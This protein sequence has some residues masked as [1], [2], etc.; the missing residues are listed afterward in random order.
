MNTCCTSDRVASKIKVSIKE[1]FMR[2]EGFLQEF[3]YSAPTLGNL[4]PMEEKLMLKSFVIH[5]DLIYEPFDS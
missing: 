2:N 3:C 5:R 4:G 1:I